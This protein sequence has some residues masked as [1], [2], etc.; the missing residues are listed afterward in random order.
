MNHVQTI[1]AIN[2]MKEQNDLSLLYISR[3]QC[4][5][6]HALLPQVEELLEEKYPSVA[7]VHVNADELP[8]IAGE[9][10]IFTVPVM[11]V[12]AEGKE[13]FRKA[14]FVP[15]EEF[16]QQLGKLKEAMEA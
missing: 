10:S 4:S 14:R 7:A 5:V 2:E 3:T 13:M 8:E 6:C 15:M 11:I 9:Y 16:D 12:F 1:E